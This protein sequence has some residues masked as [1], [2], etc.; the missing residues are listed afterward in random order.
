MNLPGRSGLAGLLVLALG[1]FLWSPPDWLVD[2]LAAVRP[3]CLY[4]ARLPAPLIALTIDDGPDPVSTPLILA[5]LRRHEAHATFFLISSRVAGREQLVRDLVTRGHEV[6][7]HLT[8][9]EPSIKLKPAQF[10]QALLE[11]HRVLAA[12]GRVTW[13]RP[14]SGWYSR[15]MID[16]IQRHQYRCALGSIYPFDAA[17]PSHRLAASYILR[18]ARPGAVVILHDGGARGLR[19]ARL[20][21]TVLPELRARGYRVVTLSELVGA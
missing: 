15:S 21:R 5:Q 14:G 12:Y 4:R 7:N 11:A 20:L 16:I 8:R 18:N 10:E 19:T 17:L 1:A 6:G 9:D 3:G 13:M 2:N